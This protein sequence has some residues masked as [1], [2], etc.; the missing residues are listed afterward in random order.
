MRSKYIVKTTTQFRK[1]Y[2]AAEK[3]GKNMKLLEDVITKLALG[4]P[5]PEKNRDHAL[6][7]TWS[8]YRECYILPDWLLIYKHQNDIL[9][10]TLA[11]IGTRSK[12]FGR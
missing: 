1:D 9:I 8:S 12:L 2:K 7:G 4:I 10:L 3:S 6:S 11:R 5:L